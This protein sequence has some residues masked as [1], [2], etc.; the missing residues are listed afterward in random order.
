MFFDQNELESDQF[1]QKL[2]ESIV[3]EA[4]KSVKLKNFDLNK[5]SIF[6]LEILDM[7][8]TSSY[9][10]YKKIDPAT[11]P[12][13]IK[14]SKSY[15]KFFLKWNN[16]ILNRSI[17]S[18]FDFSNDFLQYNSDIE[19]NDC[20]KLFT[21]PEKLTSDNP[22]YCSKCKKH[23]EATKQ[24]NIWKLPKYLI[25]T[26]KRFQA[27]KMFDT[28]SELLMNSRLSYLLQ[29]RV[30]YNKIDDFV[31]F[32][33]SGLNMTEFIVN[34]DKQNEIYD[35]CSVINHLGT[36]LSIG[37]Y[38]AIARTH[39]K[40]D[41]IKNELDWRLFDDQIVRSLKSTS[42]IISKD[43]YV[44]M[45]RLRS[46]SNE[47]NGSIDKSDLEISSESAGEDEFCDL[48][49]EESFQMEKNAYTNLNEID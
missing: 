34:S 37:H 15:I 20:L 13:M 16:S 33:L 25:I 41:T 30:V 27:K 47:L 26:L 19:L 28:S 42:Q 10:V 48:E 5:I 43:A 18:S 9:P 11:I 46:A 1:T 35:L 36:S 21:Q 4:L 44:L 45:Y 14:I 3:Q 24:M 8:S 38:T 40:T 17:Q 31:N 2:K 6:D 29:N 39:D 12:T 49:S 32:P 23:Q 7:S 22:W